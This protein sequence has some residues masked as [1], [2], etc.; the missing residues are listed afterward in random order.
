MTSFTEQLD[1]DLGLVVPSTNGLP[2][3]QKSC[4]DKCANCKKEFERRNGGYKRFSL[5]AK[6]PGLDISGGEALR[7]IIGKP[8]TST[9]P[10]SRFFCAQCWSS[11]V[12]ASKYKKTVD[13]FKALTS[14]TS[15]V[16]VNSVFTKPTINLGKR[17]ANNDAVPQ[18]STQT[19]PDKSQ[20]RLNIMSLVRNIK[21]KKQKANYHRIWNP[22]KS[23]IDSRNYKAGL[24]A[25]INAT[26]T[27]KKHFRTI[28]K[29]KIRGEVK[30]IGKLKDLTFSSSESKMEKLMETAPLLYAAVQTAMTEAYSIKNWDVIGKTLKARLE[31][32]F[33]G[34]LGPKR[35]RLGFT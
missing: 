7:Y 5:S 6:I 1:I 31:T 9:K 30:A 20:K 2:K 22:I 8:L 29:S 18:T 32:V 14:P 3:P 21:A 10:R 11:V 13:K 12:A 25:F 34:I 17:S 4:D 23:K 26:K 35:Q 28:V 19:L 24:R 15:Y 33:G 27:T 16:G